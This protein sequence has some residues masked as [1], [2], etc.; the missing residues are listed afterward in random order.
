MEGAMRVPI[1]SFSFCFGHVSDSLQ[2]WLANCELQT[3]SVTP[4]NLSEMQ[5]PAPYSRPPASTAQRR[6]P[7]TCVRFNE[8]LG[9]AAAR[10]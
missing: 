8:A 4:W 5:I 7:A 6:G 10:H 2:L 1:I 9:G 3:A